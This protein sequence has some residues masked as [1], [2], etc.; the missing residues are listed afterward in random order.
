MRISTWSHWII[1]P[2]ILILYL[3]VLVETGFY[4][5]SAALVPAEPESLGRRK[6]H[7]G[8]GCEQN[9]G[10]QALLLFNSGKNFRVPV[11]KHLTYLCLHLSFVNVVII[12]SRLHMTWKA[13]LKFVNHFEGGVI[14][15][16]FGHESS[17]GISWQ[18]ALLFP[19]PLSTLN[20]QRETYWLFSPNFCVFS[21]TCFHHNSESINNFGCNNKVNIL[22]KIP[23][24]LLNYHQ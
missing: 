23:Q 24:R 6:S 20:I 14:A 18:L 8:M 15:H 21:C 7:P 16:G 2:V 5:L 19:V 12:I 22:V 1:S 13:S 11:A 9:W 17:F 3:S 4:F 10:N